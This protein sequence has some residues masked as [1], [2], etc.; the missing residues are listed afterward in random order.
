MRKKFVKTIKEEKPSIDFFLCWRMGAMTFLLNLSEE[1]RRKKREK[2]EN[3][4]EEVLT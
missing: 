1:I 2:Q 4:R 3:K